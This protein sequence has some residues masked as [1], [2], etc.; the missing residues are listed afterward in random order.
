MA[1]TTLP[2]VNLEFI[3][4]LNAVAKYPP[5]ID[6]FRHA[7]AANS[8]NHHD[9]HPWGK[10]IAPNSKEFDAL[11]AQANN[12]YMYHL[13]YNPALAPFMATE[14]LAIHPFDDEMVRALVGVINLALRTGIDGALQT[15]QGRH[16]KDKVQA[17]LDTVGAGSDGD[18]RIFVRLGATSA[19]D[20]WAMNVPTAKPSP[21]R[22]DADAIVRRLV[23]SCRVIGR[24]LAL[25]EK[26]WAEDP[27]EALIVQR[28][29]EEIELAREFRVFCYQGRVTAV[30]QDIWWEDLGWR[31]KYS[32]GFVEAITELWANVKDHLLFNSCTMDVL[33]TEPE[34][35]K[36]WR[37][38]VIEFNGFGAHLN[39]GSDLFHWVNDADIL[40]GKTAGVTLRFVGPDGQG[41]DEVVE[42]PQP[43]PEVTEV[44]EA[45]KNKEGEEDEDEVPDWL[46][47]EDKIRATYGQEEGQ[48]KPLNMNPNVKL[49]LRGRWCGAY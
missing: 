34:A 8:H 7:S 20:S 48:E 29:S 38:R 13:W 36:P 5:T 30:S 33:M 14:V 26:L 49:P 47:L 46:A 43:V 24:M 39:T 25:D 44:E 4:A 3:P 1:A 9:K 19:K 40:H 35:E 16:L 21:L 17:I 23:T 18:D 32:A 27:G 15:T 42:R 2:P 6:P 11:S 41:A 12:Q 22:R 10:A 28:W 31:G 37:A 45:E